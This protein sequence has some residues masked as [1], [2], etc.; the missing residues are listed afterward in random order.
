MVGVQLT[1]Q[2][3]LLI[4]CVPIAAI[5]LEPDVMVVPLMVITYPDE[6][7]VLADI[8]LVPVLVEDGEKIPR[9]TELPTIFVQF[10]PLV[11][12]QNTKLSGIVPLTVTWFAVETASAP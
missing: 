10:D 9:S 12:T 4:V 6:A 8:T 7:L 1:A 11:P 2:A 3:P 5:V